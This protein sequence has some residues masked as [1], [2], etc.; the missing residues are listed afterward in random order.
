MAQQY[1]S[2]QYA[3]LP[4][5]QWRTFDR[6]TLTFSTHPI[7]PP[8]RIYPS[9]LYADDR[10]QSNDPPPPPPPVIDDRHITPPGEDPFNDDMEGEIT[11]PRLSLYLLTDY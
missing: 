8:E 6:N 5:F 1:Y 11:M 7:I 4:V 2:Y 3:Q 9:Y 10:Y